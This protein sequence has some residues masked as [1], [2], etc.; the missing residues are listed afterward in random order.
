MK[1]IITGARGL[2]GGA[3]IEHLKSMHDV[4][5]LD[6]SAL[7]ITSKEEVSQ[8]IP[9]LNPDI[10][11][12][13]AGY[14]F[15]D[16][17]ESNRALAY[18]A[19]T[20]GP[21]YLAEVCHHLDIPLVHISTDYV[22]DGCSKEPYNEEDQ[23]NPLNVYGE[24]KLLGE[25]EIRRILKK[26]YIVRTSWLFGKHRRNFVSTMLELAKEKKEISVVNDQVGCPTYTGDLV[27]GIS[28]L[29]GSAYGT[30]HLTNTGNCSWYELSLSVFELIDNDSIRVKP[31]TTSELKRPALRPAFSVL[32][33]NRWNALGKQPLRN[34]R[35]AL[36]DYLE[37]IYKGGDS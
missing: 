11:I 24:T 2:L 23:P 12:N 20:L 13:A 33:N 30:Y 37:S 9:L 18:A 36:K 27:E 14:T 10:I 1:V 8:K 3:L 28:Q 17:C 19:N 32:D 4:E 6:R 25:E 34:Y 22:F 16:L 35:Y 31:I 7:D 5:G 21:R 26:H 29:L 15:V